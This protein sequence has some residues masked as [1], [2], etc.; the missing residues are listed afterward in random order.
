MYKHINVKIIND[1][2]NLASFF[3]PRVFLYSRDLTQTFLLMRLSN[4]ANI[5]AC[6]YYQA[7]LNQLLHIQA[8]VINWCLYKILRDNI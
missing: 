4:C 8:P 5:H 3:T 2:S 7:H 6:N 1:A